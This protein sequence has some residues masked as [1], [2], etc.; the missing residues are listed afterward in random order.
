MTERNVNTSDLLS[1]EI[2]SEDLKFVDTTPQLSVS[3]GLEPL[4]FLINTTDMFLLE[5]NTYYPNMTIFQ[6]V[7]DFIIETGGVY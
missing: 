2:S 6:I 1:I 5:V 7:L 3:E 4:I